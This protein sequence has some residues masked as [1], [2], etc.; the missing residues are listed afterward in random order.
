MTHILFIIADVLG[1]LSSKVILPVA[2]GIVSLTI[3]AGMIKPNLPP[4]LMDQYPY[5]TDVVKVLKSGERVIIHRQK[6]LQR[7]YDFL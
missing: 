5:K 6:S 4:L 2:L 7:F 1:V 3:G